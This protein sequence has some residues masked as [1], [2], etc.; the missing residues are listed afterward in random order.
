MKESKINMLN[1]DCDALVVSTNGYVKKNGDA[2]MGR[3]IA[4]SIANVK[5]Y[6][7]GKLGELIKKNGNIVQVISDLND[8]SPAIVAFPVKPTEVIVAKN[9]NNI[10][11]H[12]RSHA[13]VGTTIPGCFSLAQYD[14]IERSLE[15]LVKLADEHPEWKIISCPRFGCGNGELSWYKEIEEL[16]KHHLDDRFII[17]SY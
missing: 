7:P 4:A 3:G 14:I 1:S 6:V 17:H 8:Y 12:V 16:V 15:Q 5:R 10:V 9:K 11:S 2:A 13:D